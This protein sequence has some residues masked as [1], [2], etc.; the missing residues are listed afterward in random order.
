M[1]C[2]QNLSFF[3]V[4]R[5]FLWITQTRCSDFKQDV[6]TSKQ[7]VVTSKQDVV[8]S[9]QDVVTSKQDVVTSKQDVVTNRCNIMNYINK[10]TLKAL[11]SLYKA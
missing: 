11:K 3:T 5:H 9:K 8:T 10:I 1:T 4:C 7:D 6:V 2:G